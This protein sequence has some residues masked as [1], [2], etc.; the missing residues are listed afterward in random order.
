MKMNR[1]DSYVFAP[2]ALANPAIMRYNN[3]EH[4][5]QNTEHRTQNTEHRTQNTEHRTQNTEIL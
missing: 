2:F 5:T 4:R 3:T 1:D